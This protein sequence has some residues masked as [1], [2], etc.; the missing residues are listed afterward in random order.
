MANVAFNYFEKKGSGHIVGISSIAALRGAS[1]SPAYNAS[2]AYMSNYL[3]GLRQ[4]AYKSG[5]SITITDIQPGFVN[6]SMAQGRGLFWVASVS[7]AAIQIYNA[8]DSKKKHAYITARWRII[9]WLL[10]VMPD[11]L[12]NKL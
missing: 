4:K 9:A 5:L 11:W 8:I 2:K 6:T 10:K 1:D 7:D 12:Y 3:Q